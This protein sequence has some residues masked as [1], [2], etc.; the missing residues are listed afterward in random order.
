MIY[1]VYKHVRTG[2][3]YRLIG[4][5]KMQSH[6]WLKRPHRWWETL[7]GTVGD[8]VDIEDVAVYQSSNFP[9]KIWVRPLVEFNDG[10]FEKISE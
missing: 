9:Y 7:F 3:Q 6:N 8:T 10:R 4:E 1:P 2:G 5:G